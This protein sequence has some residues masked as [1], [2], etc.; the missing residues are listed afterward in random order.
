MA[1]ELQ[2]EKS[3]K[4]VSKGTRERNTDRQETFRHATPEHTK[5]GLK[6]CVLDERLRNAPIA[7]DK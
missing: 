1:G 3:K 6:G 2:V 7:R 5:V 4:R